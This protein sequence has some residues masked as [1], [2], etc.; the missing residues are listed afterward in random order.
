MHILIVEDEKPVR[1]ELTLLLKRACYE[2]TALTSFHDVG[3]SVRSAVPA[4]VLLD[5]NLPEE[6]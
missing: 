6:S 1:Q 4:L 2:V 5:L 3:A